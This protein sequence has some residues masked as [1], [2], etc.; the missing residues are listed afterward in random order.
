[1][2]AQF[3]FKP[4]DGKFNFNN[5]H[6]VEMFLR[7]N[8]GTP[9]IAT[10]KEEAVT[11]E[12]QRMYAYFEVVVKPI[13]MDFFSKEWE[14]IDEY[15]AEE[16][17]KLLFAKK[18]EVVSNITGEVKI[19]LWNKRDMPKARLHKFLTDCI[20]FLESHGWTVPEADTYKA[21]KIKQPTS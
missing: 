21:L 10:L 20:F 14:G 4:K 12:K 8:E 11:A 1:M 3:R 2:D 13:A 16:N 17:L 15:T 9:M 6:H 7:Q 19:V 18:G 5:P